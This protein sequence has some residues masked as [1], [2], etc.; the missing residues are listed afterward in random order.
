VVLAA[1]GSVFE[2][3]LPSP[4]GTV[5]RVLE[6][7][8]LPDGQWL[9]QTVGTRRFKVQRET[10]RQPYLTA[11][12]ELVDEDMGDDV[13]AEALRD[14]AMAKLRRLFA[15]R[16]ELGAKLPVAIELDRDPGGAS[17]EIA[18]IMGVD[19]AT[20]QG[21]LEVAQHDDRLAAEVAL[22]DFA[23]GQV[24]ARLRGE[25]GSAT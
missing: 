23:L 22:L 3:E 21:L 2:H 14:E 20:K 4:Q 8:R 12:V 24:E 19:N 17:Y 7:A 5:A 13:R 1:P 18:A 10:G 11:D 15:M 6:S 25:L 16:T 9:M